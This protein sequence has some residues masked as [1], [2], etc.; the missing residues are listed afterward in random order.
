MQIINIKNFKIGVLM[1]LL[2]VRTLNIE[3]NNMDFVIY[4]SLI[5]YCTSTMQTT[6]EMV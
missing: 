6:A 5:S 2:L 3:N 1:I 4:V